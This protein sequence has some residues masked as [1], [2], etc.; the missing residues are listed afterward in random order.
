MRITGTPTLV[1]G[2]GNRVPGAIAAA[3]VDK[4]LSQSP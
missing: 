3:Q 2:N 4:L 1:F